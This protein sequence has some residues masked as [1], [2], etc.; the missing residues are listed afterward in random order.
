MTSEKL[1]DLLGRAFANGETDPLKFYL[2]DDCEYESEYANRRIKTAEKIIDTLKQV[3]SNITDE[4]RYTYRVVHLDEILRDVKYEDF[5]PVD[6]LLVNEY[7]LLLYQYS[8]KYPEAVVIIMLNECGK[9]KSILLSRN[10]SWFNVDFYKAEIEDDSPDDLPSTVQPMTPHDRQ[11]SELRRPFSGQHLDDIP[12]KV[13]GNIYIWKKADEFMKS[14]LPN[15]GYKVLE[16][17]IF[18]ECIGYRCIRKRKQYTIYMFAYGQKRT[19][20]LAGDNC[21]YLLKESFSADSTVLIMYLNVHKYI[22]G[23][24]I[25]YKVRYWCGGDDHRL[26]FWELYQ[27]NGKT[28]FRFYP[29]E[30]MIDLIPEFVYAF[31]NER[32]DIFDAI[33]VKNNPEFDSYDMTGILLNGAFFGRLHHLRQEKGIM[34]IG[35]VRFNDTVYSSVPYIDG[36]GYIVFSVNSDDRIDKITTYPFEGPNGN[37]EEFVYA[38][39]TVDRDPFAFIPHMTAVEALTPQPTERFALKVCY[40]NDECGKF[41]LPIDKYDEKKEVV[42]YLGHVFTNKIWSSAKIAIGSESNVKECSKYGQIVL[43]KNEFFL[44]PT[45]MYLNSEYYTEPVQCDD[46]IYE[47]AHCCVNRLWTWEANALYEDRETG[48]LKVLVS[49]QAFNWYGK[50]TFCT[51]DG[52]RLSSINF[53]LIDNF[54]EGLAR[55]EK[56]GHGYGF[57]D[58]EMRFVIPMIYDDADDFKNGKARVMREGK[59]YSIDH[60]GRETALPSQITDHKYQEVCDYSEGLCRVSTLK[61]RFMDLAYHSDYEGIAGTWGY[62]NEAGE[63]VI[64]PQYIYADDFTNGIALV[65]KGKWTI[66]KKWDN[67]HQKGKY[68]TEEELWGAIDKSGNEVIPFIFDEIKYFADTYE[69]LMVHYGGWKEGRWGVIDNRGNW[70][71]DPIFADIDYEYCDGLFAFYQEDKWDDDALMGIYDLKQKKVIFEPQFYSVFFHD[72]GWIEVEVFDEELGRRVEKLIDRNGNEKFHSIYSSIYTWKKPYEVLIRDEQGDRHG[73]IDEDGNVILPCEYDPAW[74]GIYY[75]QKRIVFKEGEKQGVKDFDGNVIVPPVYYEI[76]GIGNPLLTVRVGDE[77]HFKEGMIT[78]DG[79]MVVP[80]EYR[81][82]SWF[83]DNHIACCRDE[84]CEM[85]LY[86]NKKA[87]ND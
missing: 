5:S 50:S 2:A 70:L 55:V 22:E 1:A 30:E 29:R 11:V 35:Y 56:D 67:K 69:V 16:T 83:G 43:F 40:D 31:N 18:K 44:S 13:T 37:V 41:V 23:N 12:Q 77:N 87:E 53:D 86:T 63:E 45:E 84:H 81:Y 19:R 62:V 76:R 54:S 21:E 36:Y 64:A 47:D 26:E 73:L 49:G 59:R 34:K 61:L 48:L 85:L 27:L 33:V 15:N 52:K 38:N 42:K 7:A 32:A 71:V 25:R 78:P 8:D 66:D 57:V 51:L 9:I 75:E 82:I 4:C 14:F 60:T 17:R 74:D 24:E 68:W 20:G 39:E 79:T 10:T 6:G 46:I 65:C 72:D 80:A 3:Y 58:R 28:V